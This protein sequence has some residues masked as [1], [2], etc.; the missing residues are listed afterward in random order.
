[1]CF[2]FLAFWRKRVITADITFT[3]L[4]ISTMNL[5]IHTLILSDGFALL[6]TSLYV[7]TFAVARELPTQVTAH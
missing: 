7:R 6:I 5:Y 3:D 1:M 4:I 2:E